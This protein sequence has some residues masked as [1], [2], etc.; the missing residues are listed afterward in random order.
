M[1]YLLWMAFCLV[2]LG[3]IGLAFS[4]GLFLLVYFLSQ[5]FQ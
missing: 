2:T 5:V 4:G 1:K 3:S